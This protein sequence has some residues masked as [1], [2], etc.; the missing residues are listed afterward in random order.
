MSLVIYYYLLRKMFQNDHW[1]V[2]D[3][4]SPTARCS[5]SECS[6]FWTRS[7]RSFDHI[8]ARVK[9]SWWY[10]KQ[11][12]QPHAHKRALLKTTHVA[13]LSPAWPALEHSVR[14]SRTH[15]MS[16]NM[17]CSFRSSAVSLRSAADPRSSKLWQVC[18]V[19]EDF[20]YFFGNQI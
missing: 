8:F 5:A 1:N 11:F 15:S 20:Q 18:A 12:R 19:D 10:L 16:S 2:R 13:T 3:V 4:T 17:Y 7:V 6:H 14:E 9:I